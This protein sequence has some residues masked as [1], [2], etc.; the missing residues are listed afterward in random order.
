M[1]VIVILRDNGQADDWAAF[2]REAA[3]I[4][5]EHAAHVH[6]IWPA[7]E[8]WSPGVRTAVMSVELP[9][10]QAVVAEVRE[11]LAECRK[12]HSAEQVAW[13]VPEVIDTL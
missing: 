5:R 3:G 10:D 8:G 4:L 12:R 1:M 9:D 7:V 11:Q 2:E 13:F 6:G